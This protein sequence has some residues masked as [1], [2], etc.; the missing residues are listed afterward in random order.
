VDKRALQR[1]A[2]FRRKTAC[3]EGQYGKQPPILHAPSSGNGADFGWNGAVTAS[4][5]RCIDV[6][7]F[8]PVGNIYAVGLRL[9]NL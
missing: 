9:R 3:Y 2:H 7:V 6:H 1:R 4:F 8:L 5:V